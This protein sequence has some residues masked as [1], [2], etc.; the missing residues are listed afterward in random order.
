[1]K[2]KLKTIWG[3][4]GNGNIATEPFIPSKLMLQ[5]ITRNLHRIKLKYCLN[6]KHYLLDNNFPKPKM[7][8][9]FRFFFFKSGTI[10]KSTGKVSFSYTKTVLIKIIY[11]QV[12][13][14][15]FYNSFGSLD[16]I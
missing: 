12:L 16:A 13:Q 14:F 15:L 9:N 1:M 5:R 4:G 2:K 3:G 11:I 10:V 8:Y 7:C 6:Q